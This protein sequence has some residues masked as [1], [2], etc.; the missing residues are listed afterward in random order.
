VPAASSGG[1]RDGEPD[2]SRLFVAAGLPFDRFTPAT[3]EW[4]PWA[5]ADR[6]AAWTGVIADAGNLPIRV[7]AAAHRGRVTSFQ[8]LYPWTD[9]QPAEQ[10]PR[11]FAE[12]VADVVGNSV[13]F[14]LLLI[15]LVMA[16]RNIRL[17]RVDRRAALWSAAFVF[18]FAMVQ[19]ALEAKQIADSSIW[20]DRFFWAVAL[21]LLQAGRLWIFYLA[22]EPTVRRFW[23]DGLI[24]WTRLMS[25]DWRDPLV[26]WHILAGAAGGVIVNGTLLLFHMTPMFLGEGPP[27]PTPY[28]LNFILNGGVFAGALIRCAP[29]G[30]STALFIVFI[31]ALGRQL[32]RRDIYA[33][34]AT[35][36]LLAAVVSRGFIGE[37]NVALQVTLLFG[38]STLCVIMLRSFGML[39]GAS[40]FATHALLDVTPL[41]FDFHAWYAYA[42]I[43]TFVAIGALV[44]YG[45]LISRAGQPLFGRALL[46]EHA[47]A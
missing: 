26:G 35:V 13:D 34:A 45:Y 28:T 40:C 31:Y 22:L 16:R 38:L 12:R 41:T 17:K 44:V 4:T 20:Q 30:L 2:W 9:W 21:F 36:V 14:V 1:T 18:T 15:A 8:I 46:G 5:Y 33:S 43:W 23:P 11:T 3:P 39:A 6:R 10:R 27:A 42:A 32:L 47:D 24:S 29:N 19:W 25:G 7:E 37:G